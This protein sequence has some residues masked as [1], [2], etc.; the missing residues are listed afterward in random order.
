MYPEQDYAFKYY[1]VFAE[2]GNTDHFT[3]QLRLKDWSSQRIMPLFYIPLAKHDNFP[4]KAL[5]I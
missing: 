4:T 1:T 3:L 2:G 5:I